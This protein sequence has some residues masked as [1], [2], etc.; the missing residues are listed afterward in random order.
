MMQCHTLAFGTLTAVLDFTVLLDTGSTD[1]WVNSRG[2][3]LM[4]TNT[5]DLPMTELYGRGEV[6][7]TVQFAELRVGEYVVP[8]QG[9][10][11]TSMNLC[12]TMI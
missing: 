11:Y 6:H 2:L 10:Y 7:G 1:L 9:E 8:S 3:E 5:T 4:L 12:C